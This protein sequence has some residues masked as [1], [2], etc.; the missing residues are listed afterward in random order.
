M[1]IL[2]RMLT[3]DDFGLIA[4]G[5][6]VIGF[7]SVFKD[8]GLS[9]ATVQ[10]PDVRH[11][12]ISTLFWL[13]VAISVAIAIVTA[14]AAPALAWFYKDPRVTAVTVALA[15]TIVIGGLTI[16]HQ[17]LLRRQMRFGALAF[18]EV[19][20]LVVGTLAAIASALAG[21]G[22][23]S[24]VVFNVVREIA[25]VFAVWIT[26]PWRPG[27]PVRSDDVRSLVS[28]GA[29]LSGFNILSYAARNVEKM[30]IGW[31]WGA[32]P[33]GLYNN[34]YRI[35]LLPIQQINTPL[36]SVAVP[37]LSRIQTQHDRYRAYYKRGLLLT[38]TAGMP[39]VA[40][41]FVTADKAVLAFLGPQWHEAVAIFRALGPAAF[42]GT[43]NVGTGWVF[44]SLGT[45]RRMF[46]WGLI[47]SAITILGYFVGLPWGTIGVALSLSVSLVALRLPA[48]LYCIRGTHL[49]LADTLSPLWRP[50]VS[51]IAAGALLYGVDTV[52]K[53][54]VPVGLSLTFDFLIYA[55]FYALV[56]MGLPG[57]RRS[58]LELVG[59]A[60]ELRLSRPRPEEAALVDIDIS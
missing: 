7:T 9:M 26:C 56:W 45:T 38:V 32:G 54:G 16:Q 23:W 36:T 41:L 28:F 44:L 46:K 52:F 42:I 18:V 13:N 2:A 19:S 60:R 47:S 37:A 59:I 12:Q 14:V 22:Y 11:S 8:M 27:R 43:F 25:A 3:P 10:R 33:L 1:A 29:H 17:A 48:T 34:A 24:L 40:F 49:R 31:Y 15:S 39:V 4:M 20:S 35:L 57:G 6:V 21:I 50:T 51:S 55:A 53:P 5:T 30:L 58:I